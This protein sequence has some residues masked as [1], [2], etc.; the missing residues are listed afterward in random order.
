MTDASALILLSKG[1]LLGLGAAVPIGPVNVDIARRTLRQG[2]TFGVAIGSGAVT[3]DVIYAIVAS[4]GWAPLIGHA[5]VT[6]TLGSAGVLLLLYLSAMCFKGIVQAARSSD[7]FADTET[8]TR[9]GP[10]IRTTYATG[11][12]MTFFNPMTLAFWFVVLPALAAKL[13]E[14]PAHE[15]PFLCAGVFIGAWGWCLAFAGALAALG[16]FRRELWT[17][18]ADAV[19]GIVLLGFGVV[20]A[21]GLIR[22]LLP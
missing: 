13:T 16:R 6:Y 4:I 10:S 7:R 9:E 18:A 15:L 12:L 21:A 2:F 11:L 19:G 17:L 1:V 20:A 8:D 14:R 22:P 3:V 5:W